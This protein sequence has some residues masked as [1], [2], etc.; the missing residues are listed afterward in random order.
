MHLKVYQHI[1]ES[2]DIKFPDELYA[3]IQRSLSKLKTLPYQFLHENM[4]KLE[5]DTPVH[6]KI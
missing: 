1:L 4:S 3:K 2:S 5:I 6:C